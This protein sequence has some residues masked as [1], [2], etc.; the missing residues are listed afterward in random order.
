VSEDAEKWYQKLAPMMREYITTSEID[1]SAMRMMSI[2]W[3]LSMKAER[4]LRREEMTADGHRNPA[5]QIWRDNANLFLAFSAS[6]RTNT[7]RQN[8]SWDGQAETGEGTFDIG[9]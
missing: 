2:A 9:W 7:N 3:G 6:L 4:R 8:P 5:A 1:E